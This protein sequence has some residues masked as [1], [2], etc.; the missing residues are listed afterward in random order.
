MFACVVVGHDA[1]RSALIARYGKREAFPVGSLRECQGL[2]GVAYLGCS[3]TRQLVG[4]GERHLILLR[5][6]AGGLEMVQGE[7]GHVLQLDGSRGGL[8]HIHLMLDIVGRGAA[9]AIHVERS[10]LGAAVLARC[11]HAVGILATHARLHRV[12]HREFA[13]GVGGGIHGD[14]RSCVDDIRFHVDLFCRRSTM[15]LH[16]TAQHHLVA[17]EVCFLRGFEGEHI[18]CGDIDLGRCAVVDGLQLGDGAVG[19]DLC[20]HSVLTWH[21]WCGQLHHRCVGLSHGNV[22]VDLR[23][24]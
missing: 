7:V 6:L 5:L 22:L 23:H 20:R 14:A 15:F 19:V 17:H 11:A 2:D 24:G 18:R 4:V 3:A 9:H 10:L 16:R 1:E 12:L 8:V 21:A 13:F